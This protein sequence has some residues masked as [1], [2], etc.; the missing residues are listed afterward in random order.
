[1]NGDPVKRILASYVYRSQNKG[2]SQHDLVAL[3]GWNKGIGELVLWIEAAESGM[4]LLEPGQINAWFKSKTWGVS[5][6]PKVYAE[7][8]GIDPAPYFGDGYINYMHNLADANRRKGLARGDFI[9][10][11]RP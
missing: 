2:I 5:A 7:L 4:A 9:E 1:M 6:D 8:A 3:W 11:R 10:V